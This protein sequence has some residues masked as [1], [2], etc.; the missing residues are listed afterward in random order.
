[1]MFTYKYYY[2]IKINK[3]RKFLSK[4]PFKNIFK[5]DITICRSFQK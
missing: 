3:K 4:F 1:M 5:N 2:V